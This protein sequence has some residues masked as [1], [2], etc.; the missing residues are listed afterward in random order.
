MWLIGRHL[1]RTWAYLGGTYPAVDYMLKYLRGDTPSRKS[2]ALDLVFSL[3]NELKHTFYVSLK[4]NFRNEKGWRIILIIIRTKFFFLFIDREPTTWPAGNCL[5]IM[6][7]SCAMP[8][9]CVWLQIIFCTCVK[10]TLLF[11]F[12]RSF[13]RENGRSLRFPRMFIKKTN[14]VIE[15]WNNY[16]TRLSQNIVICQCLADQLFASALGFG[17]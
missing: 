10:E 5:Q 4:V 3:L 8:S 17:K 7:Y 2:A 11:S 13:L 14:S 16:W 6:V 12:L 1:S 15:W 9:N